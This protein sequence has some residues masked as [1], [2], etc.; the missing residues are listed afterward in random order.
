MMRMLPQVSALVPAAGA[1]TRL[2][3]GPKALLAIAGKPVLRDMA[4]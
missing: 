2:G 1:G 4:A 3:L